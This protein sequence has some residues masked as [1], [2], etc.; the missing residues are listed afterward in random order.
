MGI[1]AVGVGRVEEALPFFKTALEANSSVAQFWASYIDA[2]IRL[3]QIDN[4]TALLSQTKTKGFLG[5]IFD[6]LGSRIE[7]YCK[8]TN[9]DIIKIKNPPEQKLQFLIDLFNRSELNKAFSETSNLLISFPDSF[10]LYNISGSVKQGLGKFEEAIEDYK[11][12]LSINPGYSDALN[13]MGNA[14]RVMGNLKDAN[15]SYQKAINI[16]PQNAIFLLQSWYY[17][18]RAGKLREAIRN[19]TRQSP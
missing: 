13:N 1:L 6:D 16:N 8:K 5:E 19:Y 4:A 10:I 15:I 14:Y 2:L 12:A 9:E 17:T 11:K 7:E 18:K 3:G